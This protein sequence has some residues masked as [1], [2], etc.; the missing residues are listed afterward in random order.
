MGIA[1]RKAHC[2]TFD[3]KLAVGWHSSPHVAV[4]LCVAARVLQGDAQP[5]GAHG[6]QGSHHG[7]PDA[8]LAAQQQ[9]GPDTGKHFPCVGLASLTRLFTTRCIIPPCADTGALWRWSFFRVVSHQG[10]LSSGWSFIRV[11]S[12]QGGLSS[13]WSFT[14]VVSH[15]GGLSPG[16]LS[17]GW[18]SSGWF[19]TSMVSSG[20]SLIRVVSSG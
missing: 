7:L 6:H 10:A 3:Q 12:H 20:L 5:P 13:G 4:L 19:L 11:V 16:G 15:Q 8:G 2:C 14:S 17:S 9:A 1:F 18:L